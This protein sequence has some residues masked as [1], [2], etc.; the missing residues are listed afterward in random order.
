MKNEIIIKIDLEK[1]TQDVLEKETYS[2]GN[3]GYSIIQ[4]KVKEEIKNNIRESVS[5]EIMDSMNLDEFRENNY[6]NGYLKRKANE[7]IEESLGNLVK[8]KTENW[9]KDNI[10]W[11]IERQAEKSIE[12]F[13][14]PRLQKMINNLMVVNTE[15]VENEMELLKQDYEQQIKNIEEVI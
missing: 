4:N 2:E 10:R 11:V 12:E 15:A 13:L 9:V 5:R 14:I 1:I 6:G 8:E 3:T 7:I